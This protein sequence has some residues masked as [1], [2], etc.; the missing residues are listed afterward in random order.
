MTTNRYYEVIIRSMPMGL[1]RQVMSAL[2]TRVGS[3]SR[4]SRAELVR[5]I[6]QRDWSNN[7]S[8][9]RQIRETI[10]TL[11]ERYPI[12][13]DSGRG[14]YWLAGSMDEINT[15]VAE[16][17]SRARELETKARNLKE[18]AERE[19]GAVLQQSLF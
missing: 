13:S 4:I 18:M 3:Q 16:I 11:Q 15:Y 1:E 2:Q 6:Y 7:C 10:A 14:G 19:F 8:E 17:V 12:L 5:V 9:D